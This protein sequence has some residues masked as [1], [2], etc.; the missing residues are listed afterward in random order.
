MIRIFFD[1]W[2]PSMPPAA[3]LYFAGPEASPLNNISRRRSRKSYR[4]K[5]SAD[6]QLARI[7]RQP[8]GRELKI[9]K[10]FLT[11]IQIS[12][13]SYTDITLKGAEREAAK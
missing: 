3:S 7:G 6:R 11:P 2:G 10:F 12:G 5:K 1:T 13:R 8:G 9:L 4:K